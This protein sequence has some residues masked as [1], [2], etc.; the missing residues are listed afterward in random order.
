MLTPTRNQAIMH[1]VLYCSK[2]SCKLCWEIRPHIQHRIA[3]P[4]VKDTL[5]I[6]SKSNDVAR[7][8]SQPFNHMIMNLDIV[9]DKCQKSGLQTFVVWKS[10]HYNFCS[11]KKRTLQTLVVW[12]CGHYNFCSLKMRTL[13]TLVVSKSGHYN[14]CSPKKRTLQT[15]VVSKSGHYNFCSLKKRT[16]NFCSV[17]KWTTSFCSLKKRTL[18]TFVVKKVD[19]TNFSSGWPRQTYVN[20]NL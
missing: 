2:N 3:S 15:L 5:G 18:Q 6:M 10:R 16:T 8:I 19:N 12:K 17:K 14:F 9:K 1:T 4:N 7:A 20:K 11:L 13:Q